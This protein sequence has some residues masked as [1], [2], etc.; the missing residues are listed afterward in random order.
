MRQVARRLRD[1]SLELVE[2]PE[3]SAT[4]G[5]VLV[6]V[7]ASVI[8]AGTE[9]ATLEAAE[10]GLLA[11]ARARPEQTKQ[12]IDRVLRD[13]A[14]AT[15]EFV[16]Q[17]L[18]ELGPLGYSASGRVI[19][20]GERVTGLAPGDRVAIAGG[21]L[22]NHAELDVV[23][24]LLCARVPGAVTDEDA[25][26]STL[27]AIAMHGFRRSE[28][29]VGS[30]VVVIGLGLVGQLATRIALAAG[31][32]VRGVDLDP[33]LIELAE[34]AG[35][36]ALTRAEAVPALESSAD[37]VLICASTSDD[38]PIRLA[39]QVAKDRAPVVV[40]GDV[41]MNLPRGPFYDKELDL[42]LSRSYGPGRYDP[43]YE[44]HGHDYPEGYVRW[45]ERRNMEAF[46]ELVAAG[47]LRPGELVTHR[48]GI[49]EAQRAYEALKSDRPVAIVLSY[50]QRAPAAVTVPA[51]ARSPRHRRAPHAKPRFGLI[52]AGGFATAKIIPGLIEAGFE[53]ARIASA[54]G[55]SAESARQRFGFEAAAAGP[56]AIIDATDLD[57]V[58]VATPHH[59]HAAQ[60]C[61]ALER[62][63]A[64]YVEKPL[65]LDWE[66]LDAVRRAL[67]ASE[68]PLF[69]G[70]NRRYAPAALELKKLSGPRVMAYRVNAGR[71]PPEH[72]TNDLERGG[73]RLKGEG[74]HFVDFLCDQAAADPLTVTATGFASDPA[75][76]RAATDNF[77]LQIRFADGSVGTVNYAAD[78]PNGP[79]KERFETSAPDTYAVIEDFRG[80]AVWSGRRKRSIGG[81]KQDKG[82]RRQFE[83]IR[84]VIDGEQPAPPPDGYLLS[85][86]A[87]LAAARSLETGR[88]ETIVEVDRPTEVAGGEPSPL[89]EPLGAS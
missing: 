33:R 28:A 56:G 86:M 38:D 55:L 60:V 74:C 84:R 89:S 54:S 13:G 47:R 71:L 75:L 31:C 67:A 10:K 19:E 59:L 46:L 29:A 72:W 68:A 11:K 62:G 17:R 15:F 44:L 77:S 30:T 83:L 48:F 24:Q 64:V 5:H 18:D 22:A 78:A 40:V 7:A 35:A 1:G 66:G 58:V 43:A 23:P 81:R 45:T 85:T 63:L 39:A 12:V 36:R 82:F 34:S 76:A 6:E 21:G 27:G 14:R 4:A 61:A 3:P 41:K 2:V 8:S 32:S 49:G 53:P 20:V 57:L 65:A 16:R 88:T 69:V 87:T 79:G 9:R 37:A 70:F 50:P 73:G 80:G 42:R 51:P 26:F 52:G 25:A